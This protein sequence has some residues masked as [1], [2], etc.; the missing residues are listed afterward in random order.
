MK[1]KFQISGRQSAML[2][3][4]VLFIL[5]IGVLASGCPQEV[6]QSATVTISPLDS[7]VYLGINKIFIANITPP[8]PSPTFTWEIVGDNLGAEL[9]KSGSKSANLIT[10]NAI[11]GTIT[12]RATLNK[13]PHWSG[14]RTVTLHH[15]LDKFVITPT[16]IIIKPGETS[17]PFTA[18]FNDGTNI[19]NVEIEWAL[20]DEGDNVVND[21]SGIDQDHKVIIGTGERREHLKVQATVKGNPSYFATADV[22]VGNMPIIDSVSIFSLSNKIFPIELGLGE[23]MRFEVKV[24]GRFASG[25]EYLSTDP[26]EVIWKVT[27]PP[28]GK[29]LL[30]ETKIENGVLHIARMESWSN[31]ILTIKAASKYDPEGRS[32]TVDVQ[33]YHPTIEITMNQPEGSDISVNGKPESIVFLP[34]VTADGVDAQE[35]DMVIEWENFQEDQAGVKF[36]KVPLSESARKFEATPDAWWGTYT[37]EAI[38]KYLGDEDGKRKT[39]KITVQNDTLEP[40]IKIMLPEAVANGNIPKPT[41]VENYPLSLN[42]EYIFSPTVTWSVN[43]TNGVAIDGNKLVVW[44]EADGEYT[45]TA[46]TDVEKDGQQI[47]DEIIITVGSPSGHR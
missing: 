45:L 24:H 17:K 31:K 1:N 9:Q 25:K 23:E 12:I 2:L 8:V 7:D 35:D 43:P 20:T 46:T 39:M 18:K 44:R 28:N 11:D 32:D 19:N 42:L 4:M 34:T 14:T 29:K 5:A 15:K 21:I 27:P 37:V 33:V 10:S 13:D 3:G 36:Y 30:D 40:S 26:S 6:R 22:F 41:T 16:H 47:S 38:V